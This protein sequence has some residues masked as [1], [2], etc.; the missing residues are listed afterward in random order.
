M[1]LRG[2]LRLEL[3]SRGV[4]PVGRY[5]RGFVELINAG[6]LT[7]GLVDRVGQPLSV[8]WYTAPDTC[9]NIPEGFHIILYPAH[10]SH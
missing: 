9:F 10:L 3:P 2:R 7:D 6:L 8:S 4:I 5:A 1:E